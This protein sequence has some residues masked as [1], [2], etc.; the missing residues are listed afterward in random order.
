MMKKQVG[1]SPSMA[2]A[3]LTGTGVAVLS[4]FICAAVIAK[5]LD[6]EVLR[7]ESVGYASMIAHICSVFIGTRT[8][9]GR[10][11]N[12]GQTAAMI[13]GGAYYLCLL[14]VN[15]LFFGGSFTGLGTTLVLVALAAAAAILTAGKGRRRSGRKRYKIPG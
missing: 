10:A 9:M 11:G 7:M 12:M 6:S 15:A 2:K 13:T 8:A 3:V 5:L 4:A 1:R 14:L